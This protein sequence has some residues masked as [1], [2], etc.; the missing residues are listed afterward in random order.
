[1]MVDAVIR[2]W[3]RLLAA[4]HIPLGEIR[5]LVAIFYADDGLIASRAPKTLQK[6]V[7]LLTGL[8]DRVGLQTNATKTKAMN[9]VPGKIRIAL[10]EA[11]YRARMDE[12]FRGKGRSCKV[13]WGECGKLLAVRLLAGHLAKQHDVYQSFVLEEEGD[14]SPSSP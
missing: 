10:M 12:D 1:M 13:E 2:E 9:F 11:A 8:F 7:D 14:A 6:A 5:T 4:R 3:E